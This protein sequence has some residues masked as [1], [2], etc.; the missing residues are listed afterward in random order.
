MSHAE[1]III[2]DE[3]LAGRV[4]DTNSAVLARALAKIGINVNRVV[5]VGDDEESIKHALA[6]GLVLSRLVFI[7]GGLGVTP[8]DRTLPAVAHLLDRQLILHQPTYHRVEQIF[9]KRNI[10]LPLLAK[11][12]ALIIEGATVFTN[13][14]GMVPGMLLE[15]QGSTIVLLPGVPQELEA[16][17]DNG[18]LEHL[19]TKFV[20]E[21]VCL[22]LLRAFGV[23]EA[24]IATPITKIVKRYPGVSVGFYPSVSG[25][26][27]LFS[28]G[29]ENRVRDCTEDVL[30]LLKEKVYARDDKSLAQVVGELLRKKGVTLSTAESCTGGLIGDLLTNVPGSS[31]YYLGGVVAYSNETKVRVLGVRT[32]TLRRFG[33]VS[34]Q[35][36]K[37]MALG[38]CQ[39]LG[40]DV[41]I[42][43]SGIAGP[44]GGTKEKPVGLVYIGVANQGKVKTERH[45]FFG[46]RRQIKELSANTALDLCRRTL[47]FN[48]QPNG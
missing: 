45:I 29:D 8:D 41:G 14:V 32:E 39:L 13:P 44:G 9:R 27:L 42:A 28:G 24:K 11:R 2:G 10:R 21:K 25:V 47:S 48:P 46:P 22:S 4:L 7:V 26:D 18:V 3:V 20:R 1:I 35:T 5:R 34:R 33:A 37:E 12:H 6:S 43:V 23:I 16:L 38:I 15:H 19:R 40:S 31:E 30:G 36:V 17:L